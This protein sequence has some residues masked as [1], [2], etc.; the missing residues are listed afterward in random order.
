MAHLDFKTEQPFAFGECP[1]VNVAIPMIIPCPESS[2]P[3]L[4]LC[5]ERGNMRCTNLATKVGDVGLTYWDSLAIQWPMTKMCQT[6][7]IQKVR[8]IS[9]KVLNL[10]T[11]SENDCNSVQLKLALITHA[12][13]LL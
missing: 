2:V 1:S 5:P 13:L 7:C 12:S 8:H 4:R 9:H 10:N 3:Y 11:F 6:I